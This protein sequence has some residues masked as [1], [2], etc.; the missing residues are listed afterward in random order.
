MRFN[1]KLLLFSNLLL[2]LLLPLNSIAF[3]TQNGTVEGI[4]LDAETGNPISYV[5]LFIEDVNRGQTSHSDGTFTFKEI[6]AGSYTL[7][8]QR[9]GYQTQTQPI[10]VPA[11]DTLKVTLSMQSTV[12]SNEG[13]EVTGHRERG[14]NTHLENAVQSVSGE[15]LRQNLSTTLANTLEDVPG[16]STRSMGTAPGRPVMRGLGGER[17]MIL[18]DGERTGDVS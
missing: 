12:L 4:V 11:D 15:V 3:D 1:I 14:S 7:K 17:L 9:I 16:L 8:M 2:G 10:K 18:Q 5:Y 6:P 13:I